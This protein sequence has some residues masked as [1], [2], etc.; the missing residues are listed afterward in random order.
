M[1]VRD[2]IVDMRGGYPATCS[3]CKKDTPPGQL[4]PEE[5]GDWVCWECLHRWAIEDGNVREEAFWERR[6]KAATCVR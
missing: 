3:F 4:E 6:M 2:L 1:N 5:A